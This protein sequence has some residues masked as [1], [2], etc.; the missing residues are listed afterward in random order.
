MRELYAEARAAREAAE[1]EA[2]SRDARGNPIVPVPASDTTAPPTFKPD[3]PGM[4]W[5]VELYERARALL[6]KED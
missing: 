5:W 3:A 1:Q 6:Q 4:G 2:M